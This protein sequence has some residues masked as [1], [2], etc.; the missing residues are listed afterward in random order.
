[1]KIW[2]SIKQAFQVW[3]GGDPAGGDV[4]EKT[5]PFF[6]N[7]PTEPIAFALLETA[8]G[9][10]PLR[11]APLTP[12]VLAATGSRNLT[13]AFKKDAPDQSGMREELTGHKRSQP[14]RMSLPGKTQSGGAIF[15]T[16]MALCPFCLEE[17]KT[18]TAIR[19]GK[20]RI[21]LREVTKFYKDDNFHCHDP[22]AV[23]QEYYCGNRHFWE[24]IYYRKCWCGWIPPLTKEQE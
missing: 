11:D 24:E 14:P 10:M 9:F 2:D 19:P 16:G 21:T 7:E 22:N 6:F 3:M 15:S 13:N 20:A 8:D 1:M 4:K 12:D 18:E 17:R 23:I 5:A